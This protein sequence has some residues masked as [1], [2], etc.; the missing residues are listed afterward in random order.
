MDFGNKLKEH[1]PEKSGN[2]GFRSQ[3][4]GTCAREEW[5]PWISVTS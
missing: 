4:E 1:V 5:E 2:R 3:V